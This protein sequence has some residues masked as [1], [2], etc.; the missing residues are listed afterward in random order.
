MQATDAFLRHYLLAAPFDR[1]A[2]AD[3]WRRCEGR[4]C[5]RRRRQVE[6]AVG[7]REPGADLVGYEPESSGG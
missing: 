1:D 4:D 6:R 7:P 5:A 2:L 3:L